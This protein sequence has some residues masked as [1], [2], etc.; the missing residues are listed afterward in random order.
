[1]V[2]PA[3]Y[4]TMFNLLTVG[5]PRGLG[6]QTNL[7]FAVHAADPAH[8]VALGQVATSSRQITEV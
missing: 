3:V 2:V 8:V 7:L 5:C 4:L 6:E 1:M